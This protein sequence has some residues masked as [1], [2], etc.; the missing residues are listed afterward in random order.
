MSIVEALLSLLGP[1]LIMGDRHFESAP[2]SEEV[3]APT[4]MPGS[5]KDSAEKRARVHNC[6][7]TN[8]GDVLRFRI[9]LTS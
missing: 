6:F 1:V 3:V 4:L 7:Y 8:T 5:S 9:L 2:G